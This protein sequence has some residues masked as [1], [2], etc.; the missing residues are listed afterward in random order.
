MLT[1]FVLVL[2]V[3]LI[4]VVGESV[5]GQ[6]RRMM[7]QPIVPALTD[8]LAVEPAVAPARAA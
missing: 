8:D 7:S 6:I 4:V 2:S 5:R 3:A 1:A